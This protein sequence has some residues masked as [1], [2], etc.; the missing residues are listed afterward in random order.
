MT[1]E[2][3]LCAECSAQL[4]EFME[5]PEAMLVSDILLKKEERKNETNK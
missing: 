5:N 2:V 4:M 1:K 3:D